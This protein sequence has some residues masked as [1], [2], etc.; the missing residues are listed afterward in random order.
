MS[1]AAFQQL[2]RQLNQLQPSESSLHLH[3]N[4]GL[5]LSQVLSTLNR[6]SGGGGG[7]S[8]EEGE[9]NKEEMQ[10]GGLVITNNTIADRSSSSTKPQGRNEISKGVESRSSTTWLSRI[11]S[12]NLSENNI[13]GPLLSRG[14]V[15]LAHMSI[16]TSLDLANNKLMHVNRRWWHGMSTRLTYLSL[17]YNNLSGELAGGVFSTLN[18]LTTLDLSHNRIRSLHHECFQGTR[19]QLAPSFA[20]GEV[21]ALCF[22]SPK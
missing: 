17:S 13:G 14:V 10:A 1:V 3:N 19:T 12:L 16:L 9:D 5:E 15:P 4:R 18:A 7:G 21:V 2:L 11:E 20:D 22:G 8:E 6:H